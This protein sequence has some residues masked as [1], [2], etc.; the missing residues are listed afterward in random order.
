MAPLAGRGA[1]AS[2]APLA[3]SLAAAAA[4]LGHRAEHLKTL[5]LQILALAAQVEGHEMAQVLERDG[6]L[7]L[8]FE[9]C[10]AAAIGPRQLA[11]FH[12]QVAA[13]GSGVD[14]FAPH[15]EVL[16]SLGKLIAPRPIGQGAGLPDTHHL[17]VQALLLIPGAGIDHPE[18][19]LGQIQVPLH[20]GEQPAQH[21]RLDGHAVGG[22]DGSAGELLGVSGHV[23]APHHANGP[24]LQGLGDRGNRMLAHGANVR[25]T[26][27]GAGQ[28]GATPRLVPMDEAPQRPRPRLLAAAV[29]G[30]LVCLAA[31]WWLGHLQRGSTAA[32]R[33]QPALQREADSL[34]ERLE[35]GQV[36][37]AEQK[38][39][40]ELLIALDRKPE[41]TEI[42]E[43]LADQQPHRWSLRLLLA[44]LRRDQN[45][46]TGAE[47]EVRQLLNLRPD[48]VEG[49]QL[50]ALL[51][52]ETGRGQLARAQLKTAY[53]RVRKSP[54]RPE[55]LAIGLLLAHVLQRLNQPAE[56]DALLG[57]LASSFPTDQRPLLARALLQQERGDSDA[58][59]QT[60]AQARARRPGAADPRLDAVAAAWGVESLRGPS[61]P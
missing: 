37:E 8:E 35:R 17:Q 15:G 34:L 19:G 27:L 56:A 46:R 28:T 31:G 40:L 60:L 12:H 50:M 53:E 39:L 13:L 51:Q 4:A 7:Q 3:P 32:H 11:H 42:L 26:G 59:Q 1:A 23:G 22:L 24:V 49:L 52:L 33:A 38:R 6:P 57:Q 58:A 47:R 44:E 30:A 48:L 14:Q 41:A 55:T 61:R 54:S 2:T 9:R 45:D 20:Q 43:R 18:V 29:A 36:G 25:V 5:E 21:H 10:R 16:V